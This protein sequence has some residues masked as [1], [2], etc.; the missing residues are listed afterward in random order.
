MA[1]W[2]DPAVIAQPPITELWA[3]NEL[4]MFGYMGWN[5]FTG[6]GRNNWDLALHKEF[7]LPWFK[8]ETS[9]LQFRLETFNTFNH[10]H[11][12]SVNTGCPGSI[13]FGHLCTQTDAAEVNIAWVNNSLKQGR[14]S[15]ARLDRN[16]CSKSPGSFSSCD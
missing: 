14:N 16:F 11:W 1:T 7:A 12:K 8:T 2:Y 15:R 6:P 13:G 3:N 9:R 10:A 5:L 4:G